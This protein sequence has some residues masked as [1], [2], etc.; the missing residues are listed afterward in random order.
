MG[1]R[2]R[3]GRPLNGL[4]LL[5]KPTGMTSNHALQ[6][7]KRLFFAAKAGHTGSLDPLATGTLPLCFGEATKFAQYLLTSDKCYEAAIVLGYESDTQD[8]DGAIEPVASARDL[9]E[10]AIGQAVAVLKGEQKQIPPMYSALKKDGKRLYD[11]AREGIEVEREARDIAVHS[12]EVISVSPYQ[13]P[14]GTTELQT[15]SYGMEVRC[16]FS[17]SKGTYI[18]SLAATLGERLGVGG[19]LAELRRTRVGPFGIEQCMPLDELVGLRDDQDFSA[20]DDCLLPIE[21]ALSHLPSLSLDE[22]SGYYLGK[23]NPVMVAK[24]PLHTDIALKAEDGRFLGI[25]YVDNEG[26]VAPKRLVAQTVL[27]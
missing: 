21:E 19:Y 26:L 15:D 12:A 18:R 6:A 16:R 17:V 8:A 27:D 1:R 10:Q 23:G 11:L 3:K 9:S 5:D 22:R 25:G 2:N 13:F 24:A 7:C 14:P 20:M 4:F